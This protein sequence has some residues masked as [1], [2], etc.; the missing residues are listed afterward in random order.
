MLDVIGAFSNFVFDA[1]MLL[2][3]SWGQRMI[4]KC[5]PRR[6]SPWG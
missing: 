3:D 5:F 1:L 6:P 2:P 4:E